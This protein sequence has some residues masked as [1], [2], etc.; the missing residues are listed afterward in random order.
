M[1]DESIGQSCTVTTGTTSTGSYEWYE[2]APGKFMIVCEV[3]QPV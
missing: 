2:V 3:G 1:T